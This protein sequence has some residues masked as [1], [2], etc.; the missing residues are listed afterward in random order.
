MTWSLRVCFHM[1]PSQ[2][3]F[4]QDAYLDSSDTQHVWRHDSC[5]LSKMRLLGLTETRSHGC[6]I[7]DCLAG[8]DLTVVDISPYVPPVFPPALILLIAISS[9]SSP[10]LLFSETPFEFRIRNHKIKQFIITAEKTISLKI[11]SQSVSLWF[12]CWRRYHKD[13]AINMAPVSSLAMPKAKKQLQDSKFYQDSP[14]FRTNIAGGFWYWFAFFASFISGILFSFAVYSLHNYSNRSIWGE[15][16]WISTP[17]PVLVARQTDW[18]G[19][20]GN[21]SIGQLRYVATPTTLCNQNFLQNKLKK[22]LLLSASLT[23]NLLST[24]F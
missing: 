19:H 22:K 14:I 11:P 10:Q 16:T 20:L 3:S 7:L 8:S 18:E 5:Y 9:P 2:V 12:Y 13:R 17:F 1:S 23:L 4:K 21:K 24:I 15:W 6:Y